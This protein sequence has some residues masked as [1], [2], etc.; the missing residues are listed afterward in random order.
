M[1]EFDL[2]N[3]R[4]ERD[5]TEEIIHEGIA[6]PSIFIITSGEVCLKDI[7]GDH[8]EEQLKTGQ[9]VFIKPNVGFKIRSVGGGTEVWGAFVEA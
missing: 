7:D 2:L 1:P 6:G 4:L 9:V 3:I 8:P 5:G